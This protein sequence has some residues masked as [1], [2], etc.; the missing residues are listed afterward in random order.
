[1]PLPPGECEK[2]LAYLG[3]AAFPIP[4][5]QYYDHRAVRWHQ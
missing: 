2:P 4:A 5:L 3:S 1:M